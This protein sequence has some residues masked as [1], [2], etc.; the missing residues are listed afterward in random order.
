MGTSLNV[1]YRDCTLSPAPV[2]HCSKVSMNQEASLP[3]F[4]QMNLTLTYCSYFTPSQWEEFLY[5]TESC[6]HD[7]SHWNG[8]SG[9]FKIQNC[10][11]YCVTNRTYANRDRA[12]FF[13]FF[14][15][16][17]YHLCYLQFSSFWGKLSWEVNVRV[18][19]CRQQG[20]VLL[21]TPK[22][23]LERQSQGSAGSNLM[24]SSAAGV[25][26]CLT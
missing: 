17:A 8:S 12:F 2:G 26:L 5:D 9:T 23:D 24:L 13:F 19:Q 16:V 21:S 22:G 20:A 14:F 6:C 1:V 18:L 10:Y 15:T 3:S 25:T 11:F 4:V 7:V